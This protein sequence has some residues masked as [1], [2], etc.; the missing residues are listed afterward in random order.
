MRRKRQKL[1]ENKEFLDKEVI[2]EFRKTINSSRIFSNVTEHKNR[3]NLTCAVMDRLDSTVE[4]LNKHSCHPSSEDGFICFLVYACMLKDAIYKLYENVFHRLPTLNDEK[5]YFSN[6]T[7]YYHSIFD[8]NT[9]PSDDMFFEYLRSVSFAH[10]FGTGYRNRPFLQKNEIQYSPWV[11]FKSIFSSFGKEDTVGVRIYSNIAERDIC[12]IQLSF[13]SIKNY[14]KDRYMCLI[15]LTEWA[16]N[17]VIVQN[18]RWKEIKVLRSEDPVKTIR[19][20]KEILKSRFEETYSIDIAETYLCCE[21]TRQSNKNNVLEYRKA[22]IAL[23][24]Y[25]C[26]YVDNLDYERLEKT[27]NILRVVP[28]KMHNNA[29]YQLE[30][31]FCYLNQRS[32]YIEH[33]SDE[34]WGLIQLTEFSKGFAKKWVFIDIETMSYDEIHLLVSTACYLEAREQL[35][36]KN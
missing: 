15:E 22:I 23:I 19:N 20:I 9:C 24:P 25:M 36:L 5:K 3:Y 7:S 4:Y 27:L 35:K 12:D 1:T 21:L 34:E 11:I 14:I 6:V 8:E 16:K 32:D 10:P 26:D 30:K 13:N 18:E 17:E 28:K 2:R 29:Y 33:D 31:I